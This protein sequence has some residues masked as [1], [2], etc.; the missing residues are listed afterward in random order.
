MRLNPDGTFERSDAWREGTWLDLWSAVHLLS[1]LSIGIGMVVFRFGPLPTILITFLMLVL[2]E[3]LE[4]MVKI[5]ETP[6]NRVMDV[7]VGMI[8][9]LPAYFVFQNFSFFQ[10]VPLFFPML[11]INV[12]MAV[13]GWHASQKAQE[14]EQRLRAEFAEQ[15]RRLAARRARFKFMMARRRERR[16]LRR[17]Q[18]QRLQY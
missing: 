15:K 10:I 14:F 13:L 6:Q 4:A 16:A 11:S 1:G 8:S 2:Y 12:G 3:M 9:F 17:A 5:E 7:V 18:R